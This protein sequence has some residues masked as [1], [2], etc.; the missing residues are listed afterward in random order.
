MV[1]LVDDQEISERQLHHVAADGAVVQGADRGD[2]HPLQR[3]G[4]EPGLM[5]PARTSFAASFWWVWVMI[6]R[7]CART[8][9]CLSLARP[10]DDLRSDDR[11]A[12]AGRRDQ[13]DALAVGRDLTLKVATTSPWYCR[14]SVMA[15]ST[16][17]ADAEARRARRWRSSSQRTLAHHQDR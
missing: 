15:V 8:R 2:L 11:L 14:R 10:A 6:S 16:S 9:T 4:I 3:P 7:R 17:H 13:D 12:A 1:C 5:T